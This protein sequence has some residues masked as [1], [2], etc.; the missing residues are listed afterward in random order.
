MTVKDAVRQRILNLCA[1]R[2]ITL[3]KLAMECTLTQSTLSSIVNSGSNNPT[4][5][6]IARVCAGLKITVREFFDDDL[7]DDTEEGVI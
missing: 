5:A 6:T 2:D 1:M 4:L 3:N 7:F